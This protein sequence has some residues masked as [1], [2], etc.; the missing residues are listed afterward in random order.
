MRIHSITKIQKIKNLRETGY[1]I[2]EIV[3]ALNVPKT[4]VWHHIKGVKVREEFLPALKSKRGGSKIR[5]LKAIEKSISEA[6]EILDNKKTYASILSMLYWAEGN[7]ENCVFT[8]TDPKMIRIFMNTM[9]KCFNISKD[10]YLVTIRYF[11]GMNKDLC[12]EYWSDQLE[13]N[14]KYVKMYYNDGC[15][16]GKSLYG[17]CRLTVKKGGY[18]LKLLKSMISLVAAEIDNI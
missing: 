3:S 14:I 9:S 15:T 6:K 7:K 5:R 1:S 2:N 10:R 12:L 11:T 18:I 8:N 4:T 17:M 16:R 13:I